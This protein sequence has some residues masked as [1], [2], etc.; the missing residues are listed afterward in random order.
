[1]GTGQKKRLRDVDHW[2]ARLNYQDWF[3]IMVGTVVVGFFM[4]RGFG[5]RKNF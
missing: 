1:M 4:L 2:I 5:S 3:L